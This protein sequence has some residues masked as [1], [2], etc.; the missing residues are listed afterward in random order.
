MSTG[1]VQRIKGK[2]A[3]DT[4]IETSIAD[5]ITAHAGGGQA[6]AVPLVK[7]WNRIS[8]CATA[9]DSVALPPAI[10]GAEV[11]VVNDGAAAAQVFGFNGGT[12][13]IDGVAGAT[14]VALTNAKRD[15]FRCLTAG[16]WISMLEA[17]SA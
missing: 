7:R 3:F 6:T 2:I 12:D 14:G 17:K 13:T 9:A 4:F 1:Y 8:V 5:T 11:F 15:I 16:A 10:P